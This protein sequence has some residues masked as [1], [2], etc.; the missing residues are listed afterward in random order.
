MQMIDFKCAPNQLC[1]FLSHKAFSFELS[2]SAKSSFPGQAVTIN[3]FLI[4]CL[5]LQKVLCIAPEAVDFSHCHVGS[6][7]VRS[8]N[9]YSAPTGHNKRSTW[10]GESEKWE[11][12]VSFSKWFRSDVENKILNLKWEP[13]KLV[14]DLEMF[15]VR[16]K[17]S[18][19]CQP[20]RE[21]SSGGARRDPGT[22]GEKYLGPLR[23]RESLDVT[24]RIFKITLSELNTQDVGNRAPRTKG[25]PWW[26]S[27]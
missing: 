22:S 26:R 12:Y 19:C 27:G 20:T 21:T 2:F 10:S 5:Q 3:S 17:K 8:P 1:F 15:T 14:P 13:A 24:W 11:S 6:R 16:L 9:V 7:R 25:L 23:W 18:T 4:K